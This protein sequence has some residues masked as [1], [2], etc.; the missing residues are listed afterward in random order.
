MLLFFSRGPSSI[1]LQSLVTLA[2][3]AKVE[4]DV[5]TYGRIVKRHDDI[6]VERKRLR[7]FEVF[8]IK[9]HFLRKIQKYA[10]FKFGIKMKFAIFKKI[11][12]PS[13]VF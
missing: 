9:S 5:G 2:R 11:Q 1:L 6:C 8:E 10:N 7:M 3:L 4:R 13:F 12:K